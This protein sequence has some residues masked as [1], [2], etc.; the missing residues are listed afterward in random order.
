MVTKWSLYW[1]DLNPIRGSE[2]SGIR[3]VLVIS[4][5]IVNEV[6]PVV[7]VLP[8]SS[9]KDHARIYSTE[10]LLTKE[11]SSLP[12]SSVVMIHQIRT[13]AK[14]RIGS[15]CGGVYQENIRQVINEAIKLYF[16]LI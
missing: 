5:D 11:V 12:K 4:N 8:V 10:V 7:T 2:Q 15:P 3:P 13:I 1:A 16:D 9:I 6:L 14:E